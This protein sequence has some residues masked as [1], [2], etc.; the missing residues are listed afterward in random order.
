MSFSSPQKALTSS[1]QLCWRPIV[2]LS[3]NQQLSEYPAHNTDHP[4]EIAVVSESP[5]NAHTKYLSKSI[6]HRLRK[7]FSGTWLAR[8]LALGHQSLTQPPS[9][10]SECNAGYRNKPRIA[11]E[12][13]AETASIFLDP[14]SEKA[15]ALTH[16][17]SQGPQGSRR[18]NTQLF[19]QARFP[20]KTH[21][22]L[23]G[24]PL[25]AQA[26]SSRQR[27][28]GASALHGMPE[29]ALMALHWNCSSLALSNL[30]KD[31]VGRLCRTILSPCHLKISYWQRN[32]QII[33]IKAHP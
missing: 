1:I 18:R 17:D 12:L 13:H 24:Q 9:W 25:L 29:P 2:R 20:R 3:C 31:F 22:Q 27:D 10:S 16:S 7:R 32:L 26:F 6:A 28:R 4:S 19:P 23:R 33:P 30:G 5:E 11:L 15:L 8:K 21:Q 14:H